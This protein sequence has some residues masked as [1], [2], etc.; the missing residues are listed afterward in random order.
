MK[1][2]LY[3]YP[4]NANLAAHILLEEAGVEYELVLVDRTR[5]AQKS[6]EYL[7][8]NPNGTIPT[9][10]WDEL[11]LFETAAICLHITDRSPQAPL[12]P[13]LGSAERAHLYKWL[14]FLSNTVQPAYMT[15]RYPEQHVAPPTPDAVTAVQTAAAERTSRAFDALERAWTG[16]GPFLLGERYCAADA[17][18]YMLAWWARKLPRPPALLPQVRAC[19]SAVASRPATRRACASEGVDVYEP[20]APA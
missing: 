2:Q 6:P 8:L 11:V 16:P 4:G 15:F 9:L 17:Y 14:F 20:E 18:L 7:A 3:Y 19:V 10:V 5:H 13:P 1:P 12:A